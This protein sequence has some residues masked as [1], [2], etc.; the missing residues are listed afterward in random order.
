MLE[1]AIKKINIWITNKN[2]KYKNYCKIIQLFN[3]KLLEN[4]KSKVVIYKKIHVIQTIDGKEVTTIKEV[5]Y[6]LE[7]CE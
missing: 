5:E 3:E 7:T 1:I 6:D 2:P 4:G